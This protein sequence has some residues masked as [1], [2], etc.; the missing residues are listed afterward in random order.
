MRSAGCG[1]RVLL[2]VVVVLIAMFSWGDRLDGAPGT[3]TLYGTSLN[4]DRDAWEVFRVD[5]TT[6]AGTR[7]TDRHSL[8]S[9]AV[10]PGTGALYAGG[11][12]AFPVIR[13][14]IFQVDPASGALDFVGASGLVGDSGLG[15]VSILGMDFDA[16]GTLY[17]VVNMIGSDLVQAG[18]DHLVTIDIHT[19]AATVIGP[20][21]ECDG[22]TCTIEGIDGI[23]FDADG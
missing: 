10:H 18:S 1:G 11:G 20:F 13:T 6:G 23:A 8:F 9:V 17:A 22:G 4:P 15:L 5:L 7:I 2:E 3:G 12:G 21:G 16:E 19:G 14:G